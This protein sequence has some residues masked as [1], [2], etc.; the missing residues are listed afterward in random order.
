MI[1]SKREIKSL[2]PILL[3]IKVKVLIMATKPQPWSS[4][5]L[6]LWLHPRL[7][8]L[9]FDMFC[10]H[11]F[12]SN[13][14]G[15]L[16]AV[17][18]LHCL[19]LWLKSTSSR[20]CLLAPSLPSYLCWNDL[21]LLDDLFWFIYIRFQPSSPGLLLCTT[22]GSGIHITDDVNCAPWNWA[23]YSLTS[24]TQWLCPPHFS[25]CFI[26]LHST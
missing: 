8:V 9:L 24:Y 23:V 5:W 10:L 7:R 25:T 22:P 18:I 14:L 4:F 6:P 3:N 21:P 17:R 26:L 12:P 20:Y 19:S 15:T 1:E 16:S 13:I 11:E 2:F